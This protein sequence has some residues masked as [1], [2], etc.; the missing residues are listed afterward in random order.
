MKYLS[1]CL[2]NEILNLVIQNANKHTNTQRNKQTQQPLRKK[3]GR[4]IKNEIKKY[5]N[6]IKNFRYIE[7]FLRITKK[8]CISTSQRAAQGAIW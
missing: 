7:I 1:T 4:K 2:R 6:H 3:M 8:K 5:Q